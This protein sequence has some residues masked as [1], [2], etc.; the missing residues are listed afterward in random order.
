MEDGNNAIKIE[1]LK[2]GPIIIMREEEARR[3]IDV[4]IAEAR[5][6]AGKQAKI[7]VV[8]EWIAESGLPRETVEQILAAITVE[9]LENL[10]G[11][12]LNI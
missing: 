5:K 9:S 3:K 12:K 6:R 2:I 4:A 7:E 8:L 10:T 1:M 11:Q